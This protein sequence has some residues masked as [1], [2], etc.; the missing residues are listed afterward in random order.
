MTAKQ[1]PTADVAFLAMVEHQ[2]GHPDRATALL[3]RLREIM[4]Q[5]QWAKDPEAQ[6]L[7]H[8]AESVLAAP[9]K[10]TNR[11]MGTLA[12]LRFA[13]LHGKG[14]TAKSGHPTRWK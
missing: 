13:C 11:R 8:E 5:P 9:P 2:L 10:P 7:L 3:D 12:R 1:H 6:A 14:K 4:K